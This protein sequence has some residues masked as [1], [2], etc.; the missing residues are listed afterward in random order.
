MESKGH[1]ERIFLQEKRDSLIITVS[2]LK[3]Q[4]GDGY[5]LKVQNVQQIWLNC[6]SM[7]FAS[8]LTQFYA[9]QIYYQIIVW[10]KQQKVSPKRTKKSLETCQAIQ[11]SK[12]FLQATKTI[13]VIGHLQNCGSHSII[14]LYKGIFLVLDQLGSIYD[15]DSN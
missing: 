1:S 9:S 7:T 8:N 3:G 10:K 13:K 15:R 6:S 12:T 11:R 4:S 14:L 2:F 5:S